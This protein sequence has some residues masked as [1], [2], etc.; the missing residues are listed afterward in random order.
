MSKV[1]NLKRAIRTLGNKDTL[2][3]LLKD[4]TNKGLEAI[5]KKYNKLFTTYDFPQNE[6]ITR[7]FDGATGLQKETRNQITRVN[8]IAQLVRG[9]TIGSE[10]FKKNLGALV[11]NTM[12]IGAE[13]QSVLERFEKPEE[14]KEEDP[15][16]QQEAKEITKLKASGGGAGPIPSSSESKKGGGRR[17]KAKEAKESGGGVGPSP[18]IGQSQKLS[19]RRPKGKVIEKGKQVV[20]KIDFS[21]GEEEKEDTSQQ[22]VEMEIGTDATQTD[23][24][25]KTQQPRLRGKGKNT[26]RTIAGAKASIERKQREADRRKKMSPAELD[27]DD[28]DKMVKKLQAEKDIEDIEKIA[29]TE[30]DIKGIERIAK[31]VQVEKD[32]EGIEEIAKTTEPAPAPSPPPPPPEPAPAPAPAPTPPNTPIKMRV[33]KVTE[34]KK[35][36]LPTAV[37]L[38]PP[39][40][41]SSED[42]T[43]QQLKDDIDYFYINFPEKLRRIKKPRSS[44]L[45]VLQRAHKRIVAVLRGDKVDR[46]A[47]KQIGVIIKGSDFIKDKLKEIILENS[48]NGLSAEDLLVNIEGEK[49]TE[50]PTAGNYEFKTNPVTGKEY[51]EGQPVSR[52]IPTTEPAQVNT[53]QATYKKPVARIPMTKTMYRGK[54]VTA[55]KMVASN[56]FLDSRQPKIRL[57]YSY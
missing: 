53:K 6:R 17:S 5:Y 48:I 30:Q 52:L 18:S 43:V 9:G 36:V 49:D 46:D 4:P 7:V 14:A 40:R 42:K 50:K 54:E 19:G 2:K 8:L 10:D 41:L 57:K 28:I 56:P 39:E 47:E 13:I 38:I 22:P 27:A 51:A 1:E 21:T 23:T 15:S 12:E 11:S 26:P 31:E 16:T 37:D 34:I 24:T 20:R 35:D 29:Q 33:N 3:A 25:A 55:K 44:N 32:L 45:K